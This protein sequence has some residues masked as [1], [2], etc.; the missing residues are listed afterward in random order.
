MLTDSAAPTARSSVSFPTFRPRIPWIGG[1]LQTVRDVVMPA[2]DPH[3]PAETTVLEFPMPDGTGDIL[4]GTLERPRTAG[5][6]RPLA[7]LLHGLT[8]CA[9]SRYV[10]R[11][12]GRLL[13]AGFPVL[14]LNLR[15]AGPCRKVCREQYHSGRSEDLEAVLSQLPSTLTGNG[16][17]TVGWS[18]GAN[19][20]LKG[21]A[22][23]GD[24][25]PIRAAVSVSA[26][27]DLA[28]AA[29]KLG[30]PRNRVYHR[31]LLAR[32]KQELAQAPDELM[33]AI[34]K[35]LAGVRSIIE[36]DDRFTAPRNGFADAAEYYSRCSAGRFM[37]AVPVP[38]LVIH[39][40]DDPWIPGAA[41]REYDW[42]GSPNL[43]PLL[44]RRGGHVGFHAVGGRVWSDDCMVDY[45]NRLTG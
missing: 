4:S 37:P 39:A 3:D 33:P 36:F 9:D 16:L 30:S 21:L 45:L 19:L 12:A 10:L 40:L 13:E 11:A 2:N 38:T 31:R 41:Y 18:L 34:R 25:F 5:R 7:V 29:A 1:D 27:I 35:A 24:V 23:F 15:G 43:T 6:S 8:G 28:A 22:E 42:A 17:V 14:R 44:P 26:P 20:L 32:M